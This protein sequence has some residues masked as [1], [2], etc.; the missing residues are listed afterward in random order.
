MA[1][2]RADLK[3]ANDTKKDDQVKEEPK[4]AETKSK[5]ELEEDAA[6]AKIQAGFR[7]HKARKEVEQ[8]KV[9]ASTNNENKKSDSKDSQKEEKAEEQ[10]KDDKG[11]ILD[12]NEAAAKIQASFRG[13]MARKEVQQL[14]EEKAAD[15]KKSET[16]DEKKP[17]TTE[18]KKPEPKEDKEEKKNAEKTMSKNEA[19]SIIQAGFRGHQARQEHAAKK[20]QVRE[21]Y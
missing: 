2:K 19:A 16:K 13:H 4:K 12:E 21:D 15:E 18:E 11:A 14:K 8:M 5:Q 7:G 9:N 17:E 1:Q 6:A 10:K 3:A 20:N